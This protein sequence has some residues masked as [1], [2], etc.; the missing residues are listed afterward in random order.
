[1]ATNR[2]NALAERSAATP[3]RYNRG[4]ARQLWRATFG[5]SRAFATTR[6]PGRENS[7]RVFTGRCAS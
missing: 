7:F 2:N 6:Q 3:P 1:M 4:L 5:S